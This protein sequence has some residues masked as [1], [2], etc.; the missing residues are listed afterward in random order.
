MALPSINSMHILIPYLSSDALLALFIILLPAHIRRSTRNKHLSK[1]AFFVVCIVA[2]LLGG[3]LVAT[4]FSIF[5]VDS[6][7]SSVILRTN[8][9]NEHRQSLK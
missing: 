5:T 7:D 9:L 8:R 1:V 3:W 4:K 6:L 2:R